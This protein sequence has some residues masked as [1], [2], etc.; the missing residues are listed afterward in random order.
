MVSKANTSHFLKRRKFLKQLTAAAAGFGLLTSCHPAS[1]LPQ[2][3]SPTPT[4]V[5]SKPRLAGPL[6]V[7]FPGVPAELDPAQAVGAEDFQ[8]VTDVYNGLVW[9][10]PKLAIQPM[11]AESWVATRDLRHWTFQLRRGVKFHHETPFTAKDVVY[12]FKRILNPAFGS[13]AY[14]VLSVIE[15]IEPVNDYAVRFNLTAPS[16][17]FPLL[18]GSVPTSIVPHD[19]SDNLIASAPVGT[20]PFRFEE[21]VSGKHLLVKRNETYWAKGTPQLEQIQYLYLMSQTDQVSALKNGEIDVMW[22][23]SLD[24]IS[25]L[26]GHPDV[27]LVE[28]PSGAHQTII[29]Q[30]TQEPFTDNRVR[31]AFKY[32]V[33]RPALQQRMLGGRG[34]LGN[35]QP[36]SQI[37]P[38]WADIPIRSH[39]LSKAKALLA[40]AGYPHGLDLTLVASDV[41]PGMME[42]ATAFQAMA[43][44]AGIRIEVVHV[45]ADE[46]WN[47]YW[48]KVPFHM[49]SW[50]FRTSIE[51][52]LNIAYHSKAQWNESNWRNPKFDAL[53]DAAR[54]EFDGR[55][56]KALYQQAQQMLVDEGAVIIAFFSPVLLAI[57]K[58]VQNFTPHPTRQLD[59]RTTRMV[60][61]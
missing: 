59:F 12:T 25:A 6:R 10:D 4:A 40:D 57:R 35:D 36:V 28:A 42:L 51:E 53:L 37:D 8:V 54:S 13:P 60:Q 45:P 14:S 2:Q 41:M 56:R 7:A 33:D 19:R 18:L 48:Q 31:Q 5:V 34:A 47:A 9:V 61:S 52:I 30:A 3:S 23:V 1:L 20:G 22:Q 21:Y 49:G 38:N 27:K 55:K 39:D 44:P 24:D 17:E 43:A 11:L 16:A 26:N 15:G 58:E 46:Y 29:M 32:C 50:A